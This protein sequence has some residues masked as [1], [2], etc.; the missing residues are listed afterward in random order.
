[1]VDDPAAD[2]DERDE[3]CYRHPK[4]ATALACLECGRPICVDCAQHGAVG[5]RCPECAHM[6]RAARGVIPRTALARGTGAALIVA[7]VLGVVL[8]AANIPFLML[9]AAYV[10]GALT[11]AA[12]R[13]ASGGFRDAA[14]ARSAAICAAIGFGALP[15]LALLQGAPLGALLFDVLGVAIAA[16]AAW[17]RAS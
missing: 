7:I 17:D 3:Y 1:M 6:P 9:I 5:L 2:D 8:W 15:G 16:W 4:R 10:G 14:L 12:A 13:R 11:G